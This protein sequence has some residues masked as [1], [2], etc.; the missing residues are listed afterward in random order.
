MIVLA[1]D[2]S[3]KNT[4]VCHGANQKCGMEEM[5][6]ALVMMQK[7]PKV[8]IMLM[9]N[10]V[11]HEAILNMAKLSN[12]ARKLTIFKASP[13]YHANDVHQD[14]YARLDILVVNE[15]E[16]PILLGWQHKKDLFPLRHLRDA[17]TAAKELQKKTG[18]AVI[19]LLGPFGHVCRAM[20]G[21]GQDWHNRAVHKYDRRRRSTQ[22]MNKAQSIWRIK[23]KSQFYKVC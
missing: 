10:E 16:A 22:I 20:N 14:L 13:V 21:R 15:F 4:I 5:K 18:V 11:S 7:T 23:T 2:R 1:E 3:G 12:Q 8:G 17:H 9:Q 6:I 19:I